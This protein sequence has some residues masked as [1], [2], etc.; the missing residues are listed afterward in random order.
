MQIAVVRVPQVVYADPRCAQIDGCGRVDHKKCNRHNSRL[1]LS[2]P[3]AKYYY[4]SSLIWRYFG[5]I[6][7]IVVNLLDLPSTY[8]QFF[9]EYPG[10][11]I[12]YA[13]AIYLVV[14]LLGQLPAFVRAVFRI[15][16]V[17]YNDRILLVRGW[18]D[19]SFTI[20]PGGEVRLRFEEKRD[21]ILVSEGT[22]TACIY[23]G[24]IDG[25]A[26]LARFL[27]GLLIEPI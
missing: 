1:G 9:N 19:Q 12:V 8:F 6:T 11:L 23:L 10:K 27:K 22:R 17:E 7:L 16:A 25:P 2:M 15:P 21:R 20:I 13:V 3:A 4:R 14:V 18:T 26:S 24:Q 5:M